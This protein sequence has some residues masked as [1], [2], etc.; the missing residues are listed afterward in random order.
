M[1]PRRFAQDD[2]D[3]VCRAGYRNPHV[4]YRWTINKYRTAVRHLPMSRCV[5]GGVVLR[6]AMHDELL[7]HLSALWEHTPAVITNGQTGEVADFRI[8]V[9]AGRGVFDHFFIVR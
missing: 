1:A 8:W 7:V 3:G 5:C 4:P 9:R 2:T 6:G